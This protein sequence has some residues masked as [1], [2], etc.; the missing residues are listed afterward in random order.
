MPR[1]L[2]WLNKGAGSRTQV[3][4]PPKPRTSTRVPFDIDND[5]FDGT[6]LGGSSK[7]KGK[8]VPDV[9]DSDDD[10]P[11]LPAEPSTPRTK[12]RTK[13]AFRKKRA[14]SSSPPPIQDYVQPEVEYMRTGASKYELRDDEWMMVEDEFLE[15]AKLFTRH[16]HI[17]EY[18]KLKERIEAKK[19]E[20]IQAVRPVVLGGKMSAEGRMKKK[21]EVQEK[22][23]IKAIRDVFA[24]QDD[25]EDEENE[26]AV[27]R[28]ISS[29]ATSSFQ[30][31]SST[32]TIKRAAPAP[33]PSHDT[34]S[35]DLDASR[36]TFRRPAAPKVHPTPTSST[37]NSATQK[38]A[39]Q[40]AQAPPSSFAKPAIPTARQRAAT[41]KSRPTP[42]DMLDDFVPRKKGP[43]PT[44]QRETLSST[45]SRPSQTAMNGRAASS[46][47]ALRSSSPTKP[48]TASMGKK[49][50]DIADDWGAGGGGIS[51]ATAERIAKRKA[52]REKEREGRNKGAKLD[53]IPTFLV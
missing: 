19:K 17:A 53:D 3:K 5:F 13:D 23:Q 16:L 44:I 48:A 6:V 8:A 41:R 37:S 33:A 52:E 2:P 29:K 11:D 15:T 45:P 20:Q 12:S 9:D 34:D 43:E 36:P 14:P 46:T 31:R 10:L 40:P 28:S 1:Q 39:A 7:G 27:S 4:Q 49:P 18:Q 38:A 26:P 47:P 42:F 21:A 30:S 51:K 50:V 25:D 24:S 35:D 22:K 32:T